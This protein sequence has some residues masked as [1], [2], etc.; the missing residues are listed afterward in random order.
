MIKIIVVEDNS[1]VRE[2]VV[3]LLNAHDEMQVVAEVP[4]GFQALELLETGIE[5]DIVLTD[6]NMMEMDGLTLTEKIAA[7]HPQLKVIILT[8]HLRD[9]FIGRAFKAGAHGY[10]LKSG[11]IDEIYDGIIRVFSGEER[12]K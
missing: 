2:G 12:L 10:I 6:L 9:D 3:D 8:M 7:A 1:I 5:V 11:D 4:D